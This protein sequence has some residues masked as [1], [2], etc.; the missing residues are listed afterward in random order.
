MK[1]TTSRRFKM[2]YCCPSCDGSMEAFEKETLRRTIDF[3]EDMNNLYP[4]ERM[5]HLI[6]DLLDIRLLKD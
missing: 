4:S 2:S 1:V 3:L 5:D 6:N